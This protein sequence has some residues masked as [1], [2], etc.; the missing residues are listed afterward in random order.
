MIGLIALVPQILDAVAIPVIASGGVMDGRG[1]L[2]CLSL[3]AEA[4]Q[5][6]TAFLVCHEAGVPDCYK[7]SILHAEEND[8]RITRAFSGRP[9]RGIAN[10]V[11]RDYEAG[12]LTILPFPLQNALTRPLRAEASRRNFADYLSLWSG[13][14]TRL[15][16]RLSA[17]ELISALKEELS[18]AAEDLQDALSS[19][20]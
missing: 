16:R 6:G 19:K 15:A 17:R 1:I 12:E 18:Q 2:A 9:A 5:M 8:T 10:R 20:G 4:V 7:E 11:L 14:G 3:G 13:Q